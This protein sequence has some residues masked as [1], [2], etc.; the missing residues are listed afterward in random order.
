MVCLNLFKHQALFQKQLSWPS[1][2]ILAGG[3]E[4]LFQ[5]PGTFL[6]CETSLTRC[7][8][9]HWLVSHQSFFVS[10]LFLK[11]RALAKLGNS[12]KRG[13]SNI[14]INQPIQLVVVF[15]CITQ[16]SSYFFFQST[17][18]RTLLG[19]RSAKKENLSK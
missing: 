9:R 8:H 4:I 2:I 19:S 1:Q 7:N 12:N 15:W 6:V 14:K 5:F 17:N 11:P 13:E 10:V 18:M 16:G 3:T